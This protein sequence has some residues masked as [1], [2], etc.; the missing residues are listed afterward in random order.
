M[1]L[2]CL[3]SQSWALTATI[4]EM[5]LYMELILTLLRDMEVFDYNEFRAMLEKQRLNGSQK[6]ML[7]LRLALLDSCLKG[8]DESNCVTK[9]F[10]QGTLTIVE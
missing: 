5:P 2:L 10:K 4:T 1:V 3:L 6:S 7:N 8:G 9:F